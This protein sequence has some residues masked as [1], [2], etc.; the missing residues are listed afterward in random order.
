[1]GNTKAMKRHS[2]EPVGVNTVQANDRSCC[3][4]Q[5]VAR[6]C[7]EEANTPEKSSCKRPTSLEIRR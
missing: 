5:S 4:T 1:V 7:P 2:A 3:E 6:V